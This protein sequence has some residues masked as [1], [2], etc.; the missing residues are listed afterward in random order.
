[1]ESSRKSSQWRSLNQQTFY[2]FSQLT[3]I[4]RHLSFFFPFQLL[5]AFKF[6]SDFCSFD[7]ASLKTKEQKKLFWSEGDIQSCIYNNF[8]LTND[9]LKQCNAVHEGH[10]TIF[11][12][13]FCQHLFE[14][15]V[16]L[17]S[18]LQYIISSQII[19]PSAVTLYWIS[20]RSHVRRSKQEFE[21]TLNEAR[22]SS[23]SLSCLSLLWEIPIWSK[24]L[25]SQHVNN[26]TMAPQSEHMAF[27]IWTINQF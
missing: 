10:G 2:I 8:A 4:T 1:M 23:V 18:S 22:L 24:S 14:L 6:W 17:L 5:C 26:T 13:L 25:T 11:C 20:W 7:E 16:P 12:C 15:R 27:L 9:V 21:E 19:W 3:S